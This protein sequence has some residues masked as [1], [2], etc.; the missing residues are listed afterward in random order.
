[1]DAGSRSKIDSSINNVFQSYPVCGVF[2]FVMCSRTGIRNCPVGYEA[3]I[4]HKI[5]D[6][7]FYTLLILNE[8]WTNTLCR[9]GL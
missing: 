5:S 8:F 7:H 4:N 6:F 3:L 2:F 1:M 9:S